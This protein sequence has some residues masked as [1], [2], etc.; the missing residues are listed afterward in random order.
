MVDEKKGVASGGEEEEGPIEGQGT[1]KEE[2]E[3]VEYVDSL[4]RSRRCLKEDLSQMMERDKEM[5]ASAKRT[6]RSVANK[7]FTMIQ[8]GWGFMVIEPNTFW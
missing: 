1:E 6:K 3:W 2:E 8:S 4:G 7:F 5:A